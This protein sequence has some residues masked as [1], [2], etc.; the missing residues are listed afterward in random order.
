M[1]Y[2]VILTGGSR[3]TPG[4][5]K[6]QKPEISSGL[7]GHLACMQTL[8]FKVGTHKGTSPCNNL[9]GQ[10]PLGE[11]AIFTSKSSGIGPYN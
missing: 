5:L 7:M 1:D 10:V 11:L 2:H 4:C 3:N 8:P 6:Q 9:Q